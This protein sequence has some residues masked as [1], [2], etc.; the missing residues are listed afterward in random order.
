M[1]RSKQRFFDRLSCTVVV[2]TGEEEPEGVTYIKKAMGEDQRGSIPDHRE[3][4]SLPGAH[5]SFDLI[6]IVEPALLHHL[7]GTGAPPSSLATEKVGSVRVKAFK[8]LGDLRRVDVDC[9]RDMPTGILIR[10]PDID[11]DKFQILF[12]LF[13]QGG[14]F[15]RRYDPVDPAFRSGVASNAS[16]DQHGRNSAPGDE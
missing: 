1:P 10:P 6:N 4:G 12:H 9:V 15:N 2:N 16:T 14:R 5:A 11:D 8:A 7:T 3:P 13:D